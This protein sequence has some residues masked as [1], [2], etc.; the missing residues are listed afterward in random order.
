MHRQ[1]K[2]GQVSGEEYRDVVQLHKDGVRMTKRK[3][4][5]N[6]VKDKKR[7]F[8]QLVRQKR[9]VRESIYPSPLPN[10]DKQG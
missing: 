1:W 4:E 9:K 3:L 10:P 6:L 7:D 2:H 8:Y 5:L